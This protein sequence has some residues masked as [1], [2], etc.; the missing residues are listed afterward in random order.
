MSSMRRLATF[1]ALLLLASG[2]NAGPVDDC[3]QMHDPD[4]QLLGCTAYIKQGKA[5]PENLAT[6]YLNRANIYARRGKYTLAF[7]D[8]SSAMELDPRNPLIPYDRGNA[9]L[10]TRQ[11]ELA[12]ADYTRA[13]KLDAVFA[14]AYL[15]R[16]IA[17][18]GAGDAKS[19]E[20]DYRR[21][22]EINPA[23][24]AAQRRLSRL[25]SQ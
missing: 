23:I 14:L 16:G 7:A 6:A 9:Y 5:A 20:N 19:A 3:N 21:A 15:N 12:I 22:L 4:R 11:Y 25:L 24:Q 13:I 1:G 10:D 8:Y 17:Q 2:A 18:E